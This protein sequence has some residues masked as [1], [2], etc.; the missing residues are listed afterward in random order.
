MFRC[1]LGRSG[2]TTSKR[3]GDGATPAGR[4]PLRE[5][6]YRGDRLRPPQTQLR[7]R[8]IQKRDGWSDDPSSPDYNKRIKLPQTSR[9]ERL[10]RNDRLYDLIISI[11]Y[12]EIVLFA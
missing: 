8:L 9:H 7:Q 3:E 4:F 2:V 6:L 1:A 5:V 12:N 10:Y 11:G